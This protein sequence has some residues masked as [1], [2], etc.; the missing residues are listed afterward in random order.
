MKK[1]KN[2]GFKNV[3]ITLVIVAWVIGMVYAISLSA[4][5]H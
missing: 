1:L 3:V 5:T 4:N 2:I